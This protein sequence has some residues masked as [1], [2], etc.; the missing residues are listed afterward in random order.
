MQH[1]SIA[2]VFNHLKLLLFHRCRCT[3]TVRYQ[4]SFYSSI[5]CVKH[6]SDHSTS[7]SRR[8]LVGETVLITEVFKTLKPLWYLLHSC[9]TFHYIRK[10]VCLL[11]FVRMLPSALVSPALGVLV[12]QQV[13]VFLCCPKDF[14]DKYTLA[15]IWLVGCHG[16]NG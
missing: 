2:D 9:N 12:D 16:C 11:A 6:P 5:V 8:F 15:L 3:Y 1:S 10:C 4:N 7:V 14:Q 13:P